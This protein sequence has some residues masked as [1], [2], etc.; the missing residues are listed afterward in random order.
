MR[1]GQLAS[2]P[3][4]PFH[5]PSFVV[6]NP[7]GEYSQLSVTQVVFLVHVKVCMKTRCTTYDIVSLHSMQWELV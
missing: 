5:A 4:L 3:D 6:G 7:F 1:L 2:E